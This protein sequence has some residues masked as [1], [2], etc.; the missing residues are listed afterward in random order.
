MQQPD[1]QAVFVVPPRVHL[2]DV[3]GPAHIFYEAACYKAAVKLY[4]CTVY[5]NEFEAGSS[6][7]LAFHKLVPY[8]ALTL[9]HGDLVFIP[10][11]D[12]GLLL[13]N[14]FLAGTRPFQQW[15]RE[16][17]AKGVMICSVCTGAFLLAAA[18][19][20]DNRACT[21][22]WKYTDRFKKAY[23]QARLLSNRLFVND[24][25]IYT[26]AG[27]SSGI[28]LAL[29]L[30]E[31]L[32]GAH[33]AAQ[34]AKE[35]VIYFRRTIGD[36]QLSIFTQY[37]NHLNERIHRVQDLLCQSL[38]KKQSLASLAEQV[39]MSPRNMTRAFKAATNITIGYYLDKL[40][41]ER[42]TQL[43]AEGHTMQSAALQCGFK[44]TASLRKLLRS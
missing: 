17:H 1:R 44:T 5:S 8:D 36:P 34:V 37:R 25:G 21:T 9:Q 10:G 38:D 22:H 18:G 42:A 12:A 14:R 31:Q 43:M 3:T 28:D 24:A 20:L 7:E 11:L 23:P 19:L 26:S 33:F 39:N 30:V 32:W 2:L 27:V 16:Q 40:R 29:Y 41:L 15:L 13:S 4:F 6:C 35:V